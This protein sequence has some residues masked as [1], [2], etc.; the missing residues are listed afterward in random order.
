MK[1]T[2]DRL[3]RR[4]ASWGDHH[5]FVGAVVPCFRPR[6]GRRGPNAQVVNGGDG[7]TRVARSSAAAGGHGRSDKLAWLR[8]EDVKRRER[9]GEALPW[10]VDLVQDDDD[11]VLQHD[12]HGTESAGDEGDSHQL[13]AA[14]FGGSA[15]GPAVDDQER[16]GDGQRDVRRNRSRGA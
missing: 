15:G 11:E 14:Q 4:R 9:N 8:A 10:S 16:Q 13:T 1:T 2:I 6:T 7:V 5:S 12:H 3:P